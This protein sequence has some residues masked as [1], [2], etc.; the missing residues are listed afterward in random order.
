MFFFIKQRQVNNI[1]LIFNEI[2]Y[3]V[4]FKKQKIVYSFSRAK[5]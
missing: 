5:F 1:V 3:F 4:S 2:N